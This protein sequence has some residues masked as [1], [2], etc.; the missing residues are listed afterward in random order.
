MAGL[1]TIASLEETAKGRKMIESTYANREM[2]WEM[3]ERAIE[4]MKNDPERAK[5]E[6][7]PPFHSL[8]FYLDKRVIDLETDRRF[9]FSFSILEVVRSKREDRDKMCFDCALLLGT[10]DADRYF[11]KGKELLA[12]IKDSPQY[13]ECFRKFGV[14]VKE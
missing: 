11:R 1:E 2:A 4:I 10:K 5:I 3:L 13:R 7:K 14:P 8:R 9:V 12:L 6:H